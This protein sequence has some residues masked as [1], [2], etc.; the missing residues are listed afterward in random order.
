[1]HQKKLSFNH[2]Q[3]GTGNLYGILTFKKITLKEGDSIDNYISRIFDFGSKLEL[4]NELVSLHKMQNMYMTCF[5]LHSQKENLHIHAGFMQLM[6]QGVKVAVKARLRVQI[7][8][9]FFKV[10]GWQVYSK[11]SYQN[12]MISLGSH[13]IRE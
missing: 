8:L 12:T 7:F 6:N 1:M 10:T 2:F 5:L 13:L 11:G 4:S 3:H 9:K